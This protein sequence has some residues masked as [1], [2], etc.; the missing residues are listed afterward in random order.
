MDLFGFF[1]VPEDEEEEGVGERGRAV[2]EGREEDGNAKARRV[3]AEL[4]FEEMLLDSKGRE[5]EEDSV[6][7]SGE[8][9]L[10][11]DD[12]EKSK[13]SKRKLF[14]ILRA[15]TRERSQVREYRCLKVERDTIVINLGYN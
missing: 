11:E 2:S 4:W 15:V 14:G 9:S 13:K 1:G 8:E 7:D 12:R 5:G 3:E 10:E 6:E